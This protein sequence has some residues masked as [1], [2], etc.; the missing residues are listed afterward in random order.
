[1]QAPMTIKH[2]V[3]QMRKIPGG[4]FTMGRTEVTVGMWKEYCAAM[5]TPMPRDPGWGWIDSHPIVNVTWHDCNN[6]ATWAGLRLPTATEWELAATGGDGRNYPWGGYGISTDG[7]WTYP[8]WDSSKC[9]NWTRGDRKTA[10]V[11]SVPAG[12]SPFGCAD[13]IGNTWNW[14]ANDY[15]G[16]KELR[17]GS[18]GLDDPDCFRCAFRLWFFPDG[19]F[20]FFGFRVVAA[21]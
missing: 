11:G 16:G 19:S 2:Y 14:C 1:M 3:S 18:W 6:Y 10:P 21:A 15:E 17:G 8:G 13:M 9:V 5:G 20:N 7:G 12:T 4:R